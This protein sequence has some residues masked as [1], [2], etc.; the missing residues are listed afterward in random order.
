MESLGHASAGFRRESGGLCSLWRRT[1]D[2]LN[3]ARNPGISA[4]CSSCIASVNAAKS[5][6]HFYRMFQLRFWPECGRKGRCISVL[7]VEMLQMSPLCAWPKSHNRTP[8][9]RH[10]S[11]VRVPNQTGIACGDDNPAARPVPGCVDCCTAEQH[12]QMCSARLK[13]CISHPLRFGAVNVRMR[14]HACFLL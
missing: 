13:Y 4:A 2:A 6:L 3:A 11:T 12:L 9:L 1:S 14:T 8:L 10:G 7:V 5:P